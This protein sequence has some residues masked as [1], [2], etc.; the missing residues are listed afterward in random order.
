MF[1][2]YYV[3]VR[4]VFCFITATHTRTPRRTPAPQDQNFGPRAGPGP[5]PGPARGSKFCFRRAPAGAYFGPFWEIFVQLDR[6][7]SVFQDDIRL[8]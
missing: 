4:I 6:Y 5:E 2:V 3:W 8:L 1:F 7:T